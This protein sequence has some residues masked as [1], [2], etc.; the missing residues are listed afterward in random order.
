VIGNP[1]VRDI[2]FSR[3]ERPMS[4]LPPKADM[5]ETSCRAVRLQCHQHGSPRIEVRSVAEIISGLPP[6]PDPR[7]LK[8]A[9]AASPSRPSFTLRSRRANAAGGSVA[10]DFDTF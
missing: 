9:T 8:V 6:Q 7:P 2:I 5:A 3:R 10:S 4:A 1:E